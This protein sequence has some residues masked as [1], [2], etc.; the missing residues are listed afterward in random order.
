MT[1]THTIVSPLV[2]FGINDNKKI[3]TTSDRYF[4]V[5]KVR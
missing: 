2:K 4:V 5:I 3:K 1:T